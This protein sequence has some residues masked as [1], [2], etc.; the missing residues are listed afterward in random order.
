MI[1]SRHIKHGANKSST[2]GR[3]GKTSEMASIA[4]KTIENSGTKIK[5]SAI[6]K[7]STYEIFELS[8]LL[9]CVN[10]V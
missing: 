7:S 8:L 9:F 5:F 10:R 6:Q 1:Q 3:V 4:Q 2:K